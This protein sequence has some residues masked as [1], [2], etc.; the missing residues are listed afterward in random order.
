[1][2]AS[3]EKSNAFNKTSSWPEEKMAAWICIPPNSMT[4]KLDLNWFLSTIIR[5]K[6]MKDSTTAPS[7]ILIIY[8]AYVSVLVWFWRVLRMA[9]CMNSC[10]L[11]VKVKFKL[12]I[13]LRIME[14]Y[15]KSMP[16]MKRYPDK[17]ISMPPVTNCIP[18]RAK[19]TFVSGTSKPTLR[20]WSK[21]WS[22][23]RWTW[24]SAIN[25]TR[26]WL[27]WKMSL[28]SWN[29]KIIVSWK[30]KAWAYSSLPLYWK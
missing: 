28:S 1:M 10:C 2:D 7:L 14:L 23:K 24:L 19:A 4:A 21:P 3:N 20:F 13:S 12:K 6:W 9:M 11:Q 5:F 22:E 30:I 29:R 15:W 25:R 18:F 8:R 26:C 17:P 16:K 27:P